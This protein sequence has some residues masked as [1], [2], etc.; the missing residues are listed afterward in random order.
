M[1]IIP[2]LWGPAIKN[3]AGISRASSW[4]PETEKPAKIRQIQ[5]D[6]DFNFSLSFLDLEPLPYT[7]DQQFPNNKSSE[8]L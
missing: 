6:P 1:L 5:L 2:H 8:L 4:Y 7:T 3:L